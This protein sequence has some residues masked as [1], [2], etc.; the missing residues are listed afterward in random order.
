M[1]LGSRPLVL[2][3]DMGRIQPALFSDVVIKI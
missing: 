3:V 2:V 1:I